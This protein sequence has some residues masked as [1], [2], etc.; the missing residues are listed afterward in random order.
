MAPVYQ[1]IRLFLRRQ[2]FPLRILFLSKM[3]TVNTDITLRYIT[4]L[5]FIL[6]E[7]LALRNCENQQCGLHLHSALLCKGSTV[8]PYV[9]SGQLKGMAQWAFAIGKDVFHEQHLR[10]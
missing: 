10:V 1:N 7:S 3:E 9:D 4:L 6:L 2:P 5:C 8:A